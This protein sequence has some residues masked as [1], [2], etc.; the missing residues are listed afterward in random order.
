MNLSNSIDFNNIDTLKKEKEEL[1]KYYERKIFNIEKEIS[2]IASKAY[3]EKDFSKKI[4]DYYKKY[5]DE[6][7][8]D[9]I[10]SF[11]AMDAIN[12]YD[13]NKD[14]CSLFICG[15]SSTGMV[16]DYDYA[17]SSNISDYL[18]E[19]GYLGEKHIEDEI[20]GMYDWDSIV[21]FHIPYCISYDEEINV[22]NINVLEEDG[23]DNFVNIS[24]RTLIENFH[25]FLLE[26]KKELNEILKENN[27]K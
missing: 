6:L 11:F 4:L 15:I 13:K 18:R 2:Y 19:S 17:L 3:N 16:F 20:N 26:N 27:K 1:K 8:Y 21:Y 10:L 24:Y 22:S 9:I 25:N 12:I 23:V 7:I 5:S 14:K